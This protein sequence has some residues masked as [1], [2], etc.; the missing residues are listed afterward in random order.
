MLA[1]YDDV[2]QLTL[3]IVNAS[4]VEN[5]KLQWD[6]YQKLKELCESNEKTELNHPF[7]WEALADF[8]IDNSQAILVYNKALNYAN[9]QDLIEYKASIFYSMAERYFE[10]NEYR[11]AHDYALKANETA[12]ETDDLDLRKN[13][14]E[15]LL[16]TTK[17]T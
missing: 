5:T 11:K 13:I 8:T 6:A 12:K 15:F 14:S 9:E 16:E 2:H 17:N 1:L 10:E 4:S 3:D 7:Q